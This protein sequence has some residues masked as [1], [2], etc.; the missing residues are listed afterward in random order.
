MRDEAMR[1]C[2]AVQE[3]NEGFVSLRFGNEPVTLGGEARSSNLQ[4]PLAAPGRDLQRSRCR[5][6]SEM[7]QL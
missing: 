3:T 6:R 1:A 7:R 5:K 4:G 2:E